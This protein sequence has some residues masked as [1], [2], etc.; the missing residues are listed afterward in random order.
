MLRF[1]RGR[2][3]RYSENNRCEISGRDKRRN[4]TESGAFVYKQRGV[5]R[6]KMPEIFRFHGIG[7]IVPGTGTDGNLVKRR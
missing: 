7:V 4:L 6:M 5:E 1:R 3:H 2:S